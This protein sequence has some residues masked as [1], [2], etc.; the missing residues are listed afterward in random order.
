MET[1]LEGKTAL[2][3]G[4]AGGIGRACCAA[5][6]AEGARVVCSDVDGQARGD[7][8]ASR[9]AGSRSEA[10]SRARTTPSAWSTRDGR[11]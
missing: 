6:A 7:D 8:R 1:G 11:A 2:V 5:L 9:S 3:T 10:T 4:A